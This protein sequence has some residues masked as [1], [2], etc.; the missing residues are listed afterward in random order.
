MSEIEL[1][2]KSELYCKADVNGA[3]SFGVLSVS[4]TATLDGTIA[5]KREVNFK[6]TSGTFNFLTAG[7]ITNDFA[8][9]APVNNLWTVLGYSYRFRREKLAGIYRLV[10][11]VQDPVSRAWTDQP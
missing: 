8:A 2:S 11:Q 1:V 7:S 9:E 10:V 4:G 6:P 5:W 3:T